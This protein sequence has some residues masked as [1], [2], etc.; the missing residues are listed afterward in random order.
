MWHQDSTNFP[1]DRPA[2]TFWIAVD[3]VRP[4]QG[5]VQFY[6]G[7]HRRGMLGLIPAGGRYDLLDEYPELAQLPLSP[8]PHLQPGDCSVHHGFVVHEATA[9]DTPDPRW[10]YLIT[11]FPGDALYNGAPNHAT[12]GFALQRGRPFDHPSFALVPQ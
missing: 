3:E 9:N 4:E 5:P 10:S 6:S 12:D 2:I 11:Y 8:P 1:M 7:S